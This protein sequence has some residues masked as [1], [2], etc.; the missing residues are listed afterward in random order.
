[1]SYVSRIIDRFGGIRPMAA[2]IGRPVSTVQ[3]WKV[4]GSIP[5]Q[6]KPDIL[7]HAKAKGIELD[8]ADFFPTSD[9]A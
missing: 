4:R 6:I 8:P 9:A 3:S 1:M 7:L 2:V 5:D